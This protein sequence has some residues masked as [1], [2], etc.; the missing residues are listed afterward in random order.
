MC[1]SFR[2]A[3]HWI[4]LAASFAAF[5]P[6]FNFTS[7]SQ[8]FNVPSLMDLEDHHLRYGVEEIFEGRDFLHIHEFAS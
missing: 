5:A 7:V 8:D 6:Q 2:E 3:L 4:T 1:T